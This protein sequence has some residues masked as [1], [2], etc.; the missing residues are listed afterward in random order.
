MLAS[1]SKPKK[2]GRPKKEYPASVPTSIRFPPDYLSALQALAER[3]HRSLTGE[4]LVALD[5]HLRAAGL[6]PPADKVP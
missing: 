2:R 4:L 1:M 6:W 3:N 5:A